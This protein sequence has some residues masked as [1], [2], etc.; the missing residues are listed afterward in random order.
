MNKYSRKN[1][2]YENLKIC[3]TSIEN[4]TRKL[5]VNIISTTWKRETLF[6]KALSLEVY[7][8]QTS[9]GKFLGAAL[10]ALWKH[11][12]SLLFYSD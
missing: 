3:W 5:Y 9:S 2:Q 8:I 12:P 10:P 4:F 7:D 1:I 6:S 11:S